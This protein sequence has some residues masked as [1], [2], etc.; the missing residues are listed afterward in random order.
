MVCWFTFLGGAL[1]LKKTNYFVLRWDFQ[2]NGAPIVA[3]SNLN[4]HQ[5]TV[6]QDME[7]VPI[8]QIKLNDR[9]LQYRSLGVRL[10]ETLVVGS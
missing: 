4:E 9:A 1:N 7:T 2:D 10:P 3:E 8:T 5:V 6:V